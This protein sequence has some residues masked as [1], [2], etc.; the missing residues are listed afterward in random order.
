MTDTTSTSTSSGGSGAAGESSPAQR[1]ARLQTDRGVT[2]IDDIVVAKVAALAAREVDGVAQLGGSVSGALSSIF[3]RM[4][5]EGH[6]TTGV[7]VE[8][9]ERQA[10]VDLTMTAMYPA[11]IPQV[12]DSVRQNVIDR[13]ESLTGL[14]VVEVNIGVMDLQFPGDENDEEQEREE[15]QERERERERQEYLQQPSRVE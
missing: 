6:Q 9:G 4:R 1:G 5:D 7:G 3:S 12:S 11:S 13:V 8:V 15:R 10:A 14:E 2:T